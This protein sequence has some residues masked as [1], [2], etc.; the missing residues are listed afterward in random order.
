[1]R[2]MLMS[3]SLVPGDQVYLVVDLMH[4]VVLRCEIDEVVLNKDTI[5][6]SVIRGVVVCEKG[7]DKYKKGECELFILDF[8]NSNIN[9][10][11]GIII[12][13]DKIYYVFTTKERCLEFLRKGV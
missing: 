9:T 3:V 11:A 8:Y 7:S 6:Y 12:G 2:T 5:R 1:M 4:K 10:G 13:E